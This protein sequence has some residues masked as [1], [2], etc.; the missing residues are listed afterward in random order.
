MSLNHTFF[1]PYRRLLESLSH[2]TDVY[3]LGRMG[4][5]APP[6]AEGFAKL[7]GI[8]TYRGYLPKVRNQHDMVRWSGVSPTVRLLRARIGEIL[9]SHVALAATR[10]FRE[11]SVDA[12]YALPTYP[13]TYAQE[14]A[15]RLRKPLI[16]EFWEDQMAFLYHYL[17]SNGLKGDELANEIAT[18]YEWLVS[19]CRISSHIVVPTKL[20]RERLVGLGLS[21]EKISVV[22]VCSDPFT[23]L[24]S[25]ELRRRH[26]LRRTRVLFFLG[27]LS[28][29]HDTDTL[30][31]AVGKLVARDVSLV[32][33]GGWRKPSAL[34]RNA[35]PHSEVKLVYVGRLNEMDLQRYLSLADICIASYRFPIAP[36]F[37]PSTVIRFMF[38]GKPIIVTDLPEIREMLRGEDAAILVPQ[39]DA[40]A[41]SR[42]IERLLSD[43]NLR[44]RIGASARAL[45]ESNYLWD[46]HAKRLQE[47]FNRVLE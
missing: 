1:Q 41:L 34:R 38:A 8:L 47:L 14:T 30:L 22:P 3:I 2:R 32:I 15:E 29:Y 37:F 24:D 33:A 23:T 20:L 7:D 17:F 43:E 26:G 4:R 36:G 28:L 21:R 9:D 19:S 25:G 46:E 40:N 6:N 11:N 44:S 12:V 13:E 27:T 16:L 10:Y 45:A 31:E 39:G 42:S 5:Y 35:L 18:G